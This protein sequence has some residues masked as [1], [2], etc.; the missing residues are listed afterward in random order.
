L[1]LLSR[2]TIAAAGSPA[3]VLTEENLRNHFHV[4]ARVRPD[5][6]TGGLVIIP[7]VANL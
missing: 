2:G 6:E 7:L 4:R 5:P 1:L 3:D